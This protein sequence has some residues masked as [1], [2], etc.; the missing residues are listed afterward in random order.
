MHN[1]PLEVNDKSDSKLIHQTLFGLDLEVGKL[2]TKL[3]IK[4]NLD[5][6]SESTES[7]TF[8][9]LHRH[10]KLKTRIS[11]NTDHEN[12]FSRGGQK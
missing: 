8:K 11:A 12:E 10:R 9:I 4:L 7:S 6:F 3:S 5:S 1:R 2:K